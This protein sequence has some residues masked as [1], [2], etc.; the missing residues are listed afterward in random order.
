[1][2][3]PPLKRI[4]VLVN[5]FSSLIAAEWI[6]VFF[7]IMYGF[8]TSRAPEPR[9]LPLLYLYLN[10][11]PTIAVSIAS[12]R[13]LAT[14]QFERISRTGELLFATPITPLE[15]LA[16]IWVVGVISGLVGSYFSMALFIFIAGL[17]HLHEIPRFIWL[18]P[19]L[20]SVSLVSNAVLVVAVL[21]VTG[22]FTKLVVGVAA[23]APAIAAFA[24]QLATMVA[25][26]WE[27]HSIILSPSLRWYVAVF[28]SLMCLLLLGKK[29]EV[30]ALVR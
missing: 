27:E 14:I 4:R 30:R 25:P 12:F 9:L 2:V 15:Y 22:V 29:F 21:S 6:C 18:Q 1:M 5:K 7:A 11:L 10:L 13:V 28:W 20:M 8:T 3:A 26:G 23:F 16:A 17:R 24:L 19:L